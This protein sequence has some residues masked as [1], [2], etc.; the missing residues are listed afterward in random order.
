MQTKAKKRWLHNVQVKI[1]FLIKILKNWGRQLR[2]KHYNSKMSTITLTW[3]QNSI[4]LVDQKLFT[5]FELA[6]ST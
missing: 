2:L 1:C 3:E 6:L 4:T 5:C